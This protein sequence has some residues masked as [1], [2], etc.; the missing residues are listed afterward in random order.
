MQVN[1]YG[2]VQTVP[3]SENNYVDNKIPSAEE[4][5]FVLQEVTGN[6]K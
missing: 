4:R 2:P 6:K 1:F 3:N 5:V